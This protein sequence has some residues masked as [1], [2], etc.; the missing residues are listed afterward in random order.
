[1]SNVE[2]LFKAKRE[3]NNEWIVGYG[4]C[5]N[6]DNDIANIFHKQGINLMQCTS[7]DPKT[8]CQA[9]K[10]RDRNNKIIFDKDRLRVHVFYEGLGDNLGVVEKELEFECV[11]SME[12]MGLWF[13]C[14]TEEMSGY[15]LNFNYQFHEDSF[16]R[17]GNIHD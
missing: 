12:E 13:H 17:I 4:V 2:T 10:L 7:V 5:V 14:D 8:I 6:K 3:D 1:M 16:E 15:I 9:T 11:I